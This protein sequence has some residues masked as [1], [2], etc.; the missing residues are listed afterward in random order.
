[1]IIDI[2]CNNIINPQLKTLTHNF[3]LNEKDVLIDEKSLYKL[4]NSNKMNNNICL[5]NNSTSNN[6]GTNNN[7]E[8]NV[9]NQID[10]ETYNTN[11]RN[12]YSSYKINNKKNKFNISSNKVLEININND[13]ASYIASYISN[14]IYKNFIDFYISHFVNLNVKMISILKIL[15]FK[16]QNAGYLINIDL[17]KEIIFKEKFIQLLESFNVE[18]TR[19]FNLALT[20]STLLANNYKILLYGFSINNQN[21]VNRLC[22]SHTCFQT[23]DIY[24]CERSDKFVDFDIDIEN[25]KESERFREAKKNFIEDLKLI[26]GNGSFNLA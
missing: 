9:G 5:L 1:M 26:Y 3:L 14:G 8:N 11:F 24:N 20:G 18:E 12:A 25:F 6:F 10:N 23:L 4:N 2:I 19:L 17:P 13:F 16:K 15:E 22:V 21:R 7:G